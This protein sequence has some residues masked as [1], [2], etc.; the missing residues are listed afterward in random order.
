MTKESKNKWGRINNLFLDFWGLRK[1]EIPPTSKLPTSFYGTLAIEH[2]RHGDS[3][4]HMTSANIVHGVH[5]GTQSST[6]SPRSGV[7]M[8]GEAYSNLVLVEAPHT[9]KSWGSSSQVWLK[10][11][12][13]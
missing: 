12:N 5:N 1:K 2:R 8:L 4:V 11:E 7:G 6:S 9:K 3:R 13:Q 10:V